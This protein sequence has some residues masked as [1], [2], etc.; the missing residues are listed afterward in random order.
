MEWGR[1]VRSC[2]VACYAADLGDVF[3]GAGVGGFDD[4]LLAEGSEAGFGA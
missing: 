2:R 1:S 4:E 3:E